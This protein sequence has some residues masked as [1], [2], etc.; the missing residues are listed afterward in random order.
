MT[1]LAYQASCIRDVLCSARSDEIRSGLEDAIRTVEWC[2]RQEPV[3]K[4]LMRIVKETPEI[5]E[6]VRTFPGSRVSVSDVSGRIQCDERL[7][8]GE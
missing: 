2:E 1:T 3:I 5:L 4:E 6:V 7:D 8:D